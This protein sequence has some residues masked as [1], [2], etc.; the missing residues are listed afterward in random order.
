MILNHRWW[1][2]WWWWCWWQ[3]RWWWQC[4]FLHDD[5]DDS[6]LLNAGLHLLSGEQKGKMSLVTWG[7]QPFKC[8]WLSWWWW[9]I[10]WWM[11]SSKTIF[12]TLYGDV[13]FFFPLMIY[14]MWEL[15]EWGVRAREMFFKSLFSKPFDTLVSKPCQK[16]LMSTLGL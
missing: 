2:I 14:F 10:I 6:F 5:Y 16:W 4:F 8:P 12:R 13:Y 7:C 1:L 15:I 3:L 11:F 9:C